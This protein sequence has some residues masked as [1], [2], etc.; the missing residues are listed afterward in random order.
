MALEGGGGEMQFE[1]MKKE[2]GAK[3]E[4]KRG[5]GPGPAGAA[6]KLGRER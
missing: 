5:R 4:E 6:Q 2:E 1:Y 3:R